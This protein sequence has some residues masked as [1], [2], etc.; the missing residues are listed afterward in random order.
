MTLVTESSR[1]FPSPRLMLSLKGSGVERARGQKFPQLG[2]G[3]DGDVV[4]RAPGQSAEE[5][6]DLASG[7]LCLV[8]RKRKKR[9]DGLPR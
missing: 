4:G 3:D 6:G 8:V 7:Q 1:G 2:V 5:S 9:H